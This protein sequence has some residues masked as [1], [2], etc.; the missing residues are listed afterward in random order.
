M[1]NAK[2]RGIG[3]PLPKQGPD[4]IYSN[5]VKAQNPVLRG[6]ALQVAATLV[7][8]INLV[9]A[10]L[11]KNAGFDDLRSVK[12]LDNYEPRY[13]PTVVPSEFA[14]KVS[15][16]FSESSNE[17]DGPPSR[18]Y[19]IIEYHAAYKAGRITPTDVAETLLD[20]LLSSSKYGTVFV[21]VRRKE[22]LAAA[23]EST[24]RFKEGKP[25]G[26]LDGVPLAVKDEVDL[27]GSGKTL[28]SGNDL[29][30][31]DGKTS[32]CVQKWEEAGAVILG[33]L[34]MHEFG[35]D[36]TNNNVT[37]GTPPNPHSSNY[38]PGGSS[39][40]SGS[41][42]SLGLVPL[43]LGAD[44]GGSIRVPSAY[45]SISGLKPSHGRVSGSPTPS[46]A[47]TVG[48]LGP[49][50]TSIADLAIGYSIMATPDPNHLTSGLFL[51]PRL[52]LRPES[53]QKVIGIYE[54]WFAHADPLVSNFCRKVLA[55][56]EALGW[57]IQPIS[58]PYLPQGQKAHALT[59]LTEIASAA[60]SLTPN[61]ASSSQN[62]QTRNP[63]KLAPA[64]QILLGVAKQ[65]PASD[66]LLAQK[67]RN[68]LMQHLSYLF[69]EHPGMLIVTPTTP[70]LGWRIKEPSELTGGLSD[71]DMSLRAMEYVW[72]ANF[73][74]CPAI[75][76][77]V[78]FVEEEE[79]GNGDMRGRLPVGLM[80]M[81]EWGDDVGV[82]EW[83]KVAED[84]LREGS[85]AGDWRPREGWVDVLGLAMERQKKGN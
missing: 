68:L 46:L 16:L 76:V 14:N 84:I 56:Y 66:F 47:P 29:T 32:W 51:S 61:P 20:L 78:G 17:A 79:S 53:P 44:G 18:H 71:A 23:E 77:P 57:T 48:V 41:A 72:L 38:Y 50:A 80:G 25:L 10:Y 83:G 70:N 59:I 26:V 30:R 74:G 73:T 62:Q 13:D 22:V 12:E 85:G 81:G 21:D 58:I 52:S 28:G 40:A 1:D 49:M 33:K 35:L 42:V 82:L 9:A 31:A 4:I 43:A 11:W 36:T 2:S 6:I 8:N 67:L 3:Y 60:D 55:S 39:G 27:S 69:K 24:L 65:T 75:S 7:S 19:S 37:H 45:C 63:V 54:P 34:N 64:N 5:V 15:V